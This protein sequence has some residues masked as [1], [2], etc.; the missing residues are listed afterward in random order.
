MTQYLYM[1]TNIDFSWE[2]NILYNDEKIAIEQS[3]KFPNF[4]I[5]IFLS[6]GGIFQPTYCYY[7]NGILYET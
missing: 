6:N 7:K 3:K 2:D 5:E 4:R 1:L